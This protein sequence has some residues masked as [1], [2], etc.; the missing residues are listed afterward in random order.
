MGNLEYASENQPAAMAFLTHAI[1]IRS[2]AGD[3][4]AGLLATSYLCIARV[5]QAQQELE[6]A[7]KMLGKAEALFVRTIGAQAHFMA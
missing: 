6:T 1:D 3:Q 4:S 5:H 7:F 2:K